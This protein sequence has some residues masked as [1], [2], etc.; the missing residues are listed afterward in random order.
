MAQERKKLRV[1]QKFNPEGPAAPHNPIATQPTAAATNSIYSITQPTQLPGNYSMP[2]YPGMPVF[3]QQALMMMQY[4]YMM[5]NQ[6][7]GQQQF[8][9]PEA[10]PGPQPP[11]GDFQFDYEEYQKNPQ[12]YLK[13]LPPDI[14]DKLQDQVLEDEEKTQE[15]EI[16]AIINE[17]EEVFHRESKDCKCCKGYI[18]KCKDFLCKKLEV[19]KCY[20]SQLEEQE[21]DERL[22]EECRDCSCCKGYVYTCLGEQCKLAGICHCFDGGLAAGADKA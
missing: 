8:Y 19:C 4:N 11:F 7:A 18:Y 5:Q 6:Q 21:H 2:V 12:E 14:L 13:T 20:A 15:N 17:M 1:G 9:A 22:I 10:D 3:D 16:N